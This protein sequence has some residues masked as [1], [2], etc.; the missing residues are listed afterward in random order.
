MTRRMLSPPTSGC[1]RT[2][3][4]CAGRARSAAGASAVVV[5][6]RF[7]RVSSRPIWRMVAGAGVVL[8]GSFIA[9][10]MSRPELAQ[11]SWAAWRAP[12]LDTLLQGVILVFAAT[13]VVWGILKYLD[14]TRVGQ[15]LQVGTAACLSILFAG[16]GL[17]EIPLGLAAIVLLQEHG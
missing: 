2:V 8:V 5:L 13:A 4:L 16:R 1:R 9:V 11:A 7:A 10:Q 14:P 15:V 17:A 3:A 6:D 12:L